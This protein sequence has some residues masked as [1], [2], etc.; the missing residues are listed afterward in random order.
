MLQGHV[1]CSVKRQS[2]E[3]VVVHQLRN[4]AE[5][6]AALVQCVAQALAGFS[7]CHYDVYTTVTGL[8]S[9]GVLAGP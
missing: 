2:V 1:L 4:T 5:H 9:D 7:L 8:Q 6:T 3:A